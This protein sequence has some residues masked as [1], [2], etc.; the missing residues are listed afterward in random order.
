MPD[1]IQDPN[2]SKKQVPGTQPDNY[3]GSAVVPATAS[4][5][6]SPSSVMFNATNGTIGFFFGSSASFSALEAGSV[7]SVTAS[8][9]YVSFGTPT[10]GTTLNIHPCAWSGSATDSVTFIYKGGLDGGGI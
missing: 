6:K 9:H 4:F 8:R 5:V 3:Y 10:E 7:N 2:D 1:Y